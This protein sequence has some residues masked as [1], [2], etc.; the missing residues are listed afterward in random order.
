MNKPRQVE[1]DVVLWDDPQVIVHSGTY[2]AT[3]KVKIAVREL[4]PYRIF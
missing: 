1:G 4:V 3:V 2:T